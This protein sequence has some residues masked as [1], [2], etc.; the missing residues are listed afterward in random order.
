M[1]VQH[2]VSAIV[3]QLGEDHREGAGGPQRRG[4]PDEKHIR[5]RE[6]GDVADPL[7]KRVLAE[8]SEDMTDDP[9]LSVTHG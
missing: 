9:G 2:Y 3:Y 6:T 5:I 1:V 7:A 4:S 8:P